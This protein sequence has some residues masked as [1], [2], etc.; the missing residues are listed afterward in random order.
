MASKVNQHDL[1]RYIPSDKRR[2]L[3][4]ICGFGCVV[5]AS[6]IYDYEHIEPEWQDAHGHDVNKMALLCGTCHGQ[7]TR[8]QWSKEKIWEALAKPKALQQGGATAM[9][10]YD[11][12]PL[13]IEAGGA[14]IYDPENVLTMF[15]T[16]LL[17]IKPPEEVGAPIRISGTFY[18]S[19][20]AL[21][22][23]IDDNRWQAGTGVWDIETAG[24]RTTLRRGPRDIALVLRAEPREKLI[25]ER[26]DMF[27]KGVRVYVDE[28]GICFGPPGSTLFGFS[29]EIIQPI[30]A[31]NISVDD[32]R[33]TNAMFTVGVPTSGQFTNNTATGADLAMCW[34][35]QGHV[36]GIGYKSVK[37]SGS[38]ISVDP[39]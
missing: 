20:G 10:D 3:R 9:Y 29:G 7:V 31:F 8:K 5:C 33:E 11:M 26:M 36:I 1:L 14:K 38:L 21:V 18:D 22:F 25:I 35:G 6:S 13:W 32:G 23:S 19:S 30:S 16:P 15:G 28:Q 27:Y 24:Q 37:C 17:Q 2:E 12:K 4:K 39:K 34:R